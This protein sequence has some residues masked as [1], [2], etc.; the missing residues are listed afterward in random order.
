[1]PF[2]DLRHCDL[3]DF[4]KEIRKFMERNELSTRQFA[5]WSGISAS[6]IYKIEEGKTITLETIKIIQEFM[7]SFKPG[8][9]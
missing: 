4:A 7:A 2:P 5:D 3:R 8:A 1:M 6:T 9:S